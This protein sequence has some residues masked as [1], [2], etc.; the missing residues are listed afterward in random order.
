LIAEHHFLGYKRPVGEHLK[1]VAW[2]LGRPIACVLWSSAPRHLAPRD[3]Y[4]GWSAAA[5]QRNLRYLAYNTRFL[6]VPW[7]RV[8]HL[9]SHLLGR[10]AR[11]VPAEWQRVYGHTIHYLETFVDPSR[12]R[13][14]CYLAANWISLGLTSGRGHNART[15]RADQ[16]KK[17][18][19]GYPL[20][21]R[22]RELL[23]QVD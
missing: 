9:A 8:P 16:P 6:I 10:M 19:L 23:G 18:L 15:N 11:L 17:L 2:A 21:H 12:N 7:V 1:L 4:I 20:T 5:R 14:T 13:G 3:R 22:F